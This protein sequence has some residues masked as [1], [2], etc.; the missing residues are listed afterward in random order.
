MAAIASALSAVSLI[1]LSRG[2]DPGGVSTSV[3]VG[4]FVLVVA[5]LQALRFSRS[6]AFHYLF[7][8]VLA[9]GGFAIWLWWSSDTGDNAGGALIA[10]AM[11]S[12]GLGR[13]SK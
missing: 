9:A 12:F 1:N 6:R 13:L 11:V 8:A 5:N 4:V 7:W 2:V 10:S 3:I